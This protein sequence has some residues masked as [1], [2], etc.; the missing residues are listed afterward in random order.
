ML[1]AAKSSTK[2]PQAS[3]NTYTID[4]VV[5]W[6][7]VEARLLSKSKVAYEKFTCL[8]NNISAFRSTLPDG[9]LF[10]SLKLQGKEFIVISQATD[11]PLMVNW[12]NNQLVTLIADLDH[13]IRRAKEGRTEFS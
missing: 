2:S 10:G 11:E 5:I 9:C 1:N 8:T 12:T 7:L 3:W 4:K 13:L 6:E